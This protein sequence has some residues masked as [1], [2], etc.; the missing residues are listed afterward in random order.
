MGFFSVGEIM[1]EEIS[2][3]IEVYWKL[4]MFMLILQNVLIFKIQDLVK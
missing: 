1:L 3:K 2:D 4:L